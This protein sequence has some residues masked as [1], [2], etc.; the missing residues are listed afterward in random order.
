MSEVYDINTTSNTKNVAKLLQIFNYFIQY[1]KNARY[2]EGSLTN[3]SGTDYAESIKTNGRFIEQKVLEVR[4]K[5][6]IDIIKPRLTIKSQLS[7]EVKKELEEIIE[8]KN[9][10]S[11]D[12]ILDGFSFFRADED[13]RKIK[14]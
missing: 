12:T 10:V 9:L 4:K 6:L 7:N 1:E 13:K 8:T 3:N 14:N 5:E 11:L 2:R